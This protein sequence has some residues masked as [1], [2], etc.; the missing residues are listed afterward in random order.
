LDLFH[1]SRIVGCG[2]ILAEFYCTGLDT[3]IGIID[4]VVEES[5]GTVGLCGDAV[6]L[7]VRLH[8]STSG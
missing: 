2:A 5:G 7:L 6:M 1:T 4:I 8:Q 3:V